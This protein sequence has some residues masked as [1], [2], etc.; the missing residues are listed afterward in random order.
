MNLV[1]AWRFLSALHILQTDLAREC[2]GS[3]S[4]REQ[5]WTCRPLSF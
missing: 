3:D 1:E 4:R 2:G 5:T